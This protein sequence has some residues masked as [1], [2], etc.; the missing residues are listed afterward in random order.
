MH[1]IEIMSGFKHIR[2]EL[3]SKCRI[4]KPIYELALW[5]YFADNT[6]TV[7]DLENHKSSLCLAIKDSANLNPWV[8]RLEDES[9]GGRLLKHATK[10][11]DRDPRKYLNKQ[12]QQLGYM[13]FRFLK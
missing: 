6:L 3:H 5:F 1:S 11:Y 9:P 12:Y 4:N 7:H 10:N 8:I 13:P 2:T